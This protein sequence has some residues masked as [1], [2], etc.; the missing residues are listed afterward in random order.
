VAYFEFRLKRLRR[1][2]KR[3]SPSRFDPWAKTLPKRP[4]PEARQ[5][6]AAGVAYFEF[7]LKCLVRAQVELAAATRLCHNGLSRQLAKSLLLESHILNIGSSARREIE[8]VRAQVDSTRGP[9]LCQNGLSR[10][11]PKCLLLES[12]ILNFGSSA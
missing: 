1:D 6:L 3:Q 4:A 12:H 9:K 5:E 11:L 8:S 7:R 10:Q 2:G